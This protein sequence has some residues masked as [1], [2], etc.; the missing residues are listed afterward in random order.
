MS[1]KRNLRMDNAKGVL[2]MLVVI[3][4]FLLPLQGRTRVCTNL[5]YEIYV[6]HM[7][8][9]TFVSGLFSQNIYIGKEKR[10]FNVRQLFKTLWLYAIF[11]IIVF[12]SEIP[13]YGREASWREFFYEE[14]APWYML[15][16]FTWYLFIPFFTL[17]KER[18]FKSSIILILLLTAASLAGGYIEGLGEL[19]SFER[20]LAFAPFFYAGHFMGTERLEAFLRA[21]GKTDI[22]ALWCVIE[23]SAAFFVLGI[24]FFMYDYLL[25]YHD[26]VFGVWY[27]RFRICERPEYFTGILGQVWIL[28]LIW[29][30]AASVI[31]LTFFRIVPACYVPVLSVMGQRT[32]QIYILHRPVR[33]LLFAAGLITCFDPGNPLD[34]IIVL[35]FCIVLSMLLSASVFTKFFELLLFPFR[36]N[37]N[38]I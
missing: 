26:A 17:L 27:E 21:E 10:T 31:S 16:L 5:F 30:V 9:F 13:A 25:P 12:F 7:A 24:A 18:V 19:L 20:I 15:A 35:L 1:V 37:I 6:F 2:I 36:K 34:L 38:R 4:H 8:A 3:G 22:K 11:E 32:L 29:Y 14:G 23:A 33:D 28:R